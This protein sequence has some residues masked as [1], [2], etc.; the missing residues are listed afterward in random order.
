MSIHVE[1][2]GTGPDLV[3]LHGWGLH[4]GVFGALAEQLAGRYRVTVV[5][6]PGHG[7]SPAPA[8]QQDLSALADSV[9]V[10]APPRAAWLGWSLGGMIAAQLALRA[11]QRVDNL[12]LVASSPR[13]ITGNGWP[14]AMDPAVLAGFARELQEDYRGTLDRFLS[15]RVGLNTAAGR[16]TLRLL[17]EMLFQF[18]SPAPQ[19]LRDGL[20]ILSS[21][22]LRAQLPALRCPV[23]YILG[24]RD[25]LVPVGV[26]PGLTALFPAA[27]VEIISGAGHAPFL[28]HQA[29]F[30]AVLAPFLEHAYD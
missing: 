2:F 21:A 24:E 19:A 15:L 17:R 12:I 13:F 30:L 6:L 10:V 1:Q 22:D 23:L 5:D 18:P 28:S 4:G 29:A 26:G 16:S 27:R 14:Y 11:P 8:Q 7:R 25:R 9:A 20:A 3:L